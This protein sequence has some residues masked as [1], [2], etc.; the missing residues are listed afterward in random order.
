MSNTFAEGLAETS[1]GALAMIQPV[2]SQ[3]ASQAASQGVF[4]TMMAA[5]KQKKSKGPAPLASGITALAQ[6]CCRSQEEALLARIFAS[7]A[8]AVTPLATAAGLCAQRLAEGCSQAQCV[9]PRRSLWVCAGRSDPPGCRLQ[10]RVQKRKAEAAAQAEVVRKQQVEQRMQKCNAPSQLLPSGRAEVQRIASQELCSMDSLERLS[11]SGCSAEAAEGTTLA[12]CQDDAH[13]KSS[14]G[15]C[16][17]SQ[18]A[19]SVSQQAS[20]RTMDPVKRMRLQALQQELTAAR[21][22]VADLERMIKAEE[23]G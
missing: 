20:A 7:Q 23:M 13:E 5:S 22:T 12:S 8:A 18:P 19:Q 2:E 4:D 10:E 1:Q 9:S 17:P 16:M 11:K 6:S 15:R 21:Q 14:E 3:P